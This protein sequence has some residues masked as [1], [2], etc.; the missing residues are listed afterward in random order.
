MTTYESIRLLKDLLVLVQWDYI[1]L[2]EGHK[3]R[4]PDAE[5]TLACK[6][7]KYN[8]WIR[9]SPVSFI[10]CLIFNSYP[11]SSPFTHLLSPPL[12]FISCFL[13]FHSSPF[14]LPFI[15]L[16]SPRISLISCLLAL[17]SS[18]FSSPF[19][20]LLS[21]PLSSPVSLSL[22]VSV[23]S[24]RLHTESSHLALQSKII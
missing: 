5:I 15:H 21:P 7:V 12:S 23:Y 1:I 22:F 20:H 14:S 18:P 11:V 6:Q 9:L 24:C 13:T 8:N 10:S 17:H 4:N 19:T 2:D 3:I 16:L